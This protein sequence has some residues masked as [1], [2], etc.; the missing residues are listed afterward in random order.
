MFLQLKQI[1]LADFSRAA[2]ELLWLISSTFL[3]MNVLCLFGIFSLTMVNVFCWI[4]HKSD[5]NWLN[6]C[7]AQLLVNLNGISF[8][9]C[10]LQVSFCFKFGKIDLCIEYNTLVRSLPSDYRF[11]KQ[12]YCHKISLKVKATLFDVCKAS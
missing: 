8:A 10:C 2:S 11:A 5:W 7:L 4:A 9:R 1:S 3:R 12:K 6:C